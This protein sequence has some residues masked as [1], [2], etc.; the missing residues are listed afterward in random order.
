MKYRNFLADIVG[1]IVRDRKRPTE[2]QIRARAESVVEARDLT[3]FIEMTLREFARLND[4]N[5]TRF[6][7]RPS[8]YRDWF[9]AVK[10]PPTRR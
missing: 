6:R 1:G 7:I 2:D 10:A 4:G 5:I 3:K 9:N 8:E